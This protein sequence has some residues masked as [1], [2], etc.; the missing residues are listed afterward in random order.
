MGGEALTLPAAQREPP[1]APAPGARQAGL[2]RILP[3][4]LQVVVQRGLA[5]RARELLANSSAL[6]EAA[7]REQQRLGRGECRGAPAPVAFG[8]AVVGD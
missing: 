4:C 7:L 8:G 1:H 6:A 2:S 5:P 3:P